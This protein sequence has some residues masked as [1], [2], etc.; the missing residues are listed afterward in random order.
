M[1]LNIVILNWNGFHYTKNCINSI[2]NSDFKDYKLIIV[3]NNSTDDSLH[4]LKKIF[5]KNKKIIFK[6]NK[7]NY[8]SFGFNFGLNHSNSE[9]V[10]MLNN[11]ALVNKNTL[12]TL[13]KTFQQNKRIGVVSPLVYDSKNNISKING[14]GIIDLKNGGGRPFNKSKGLIEYPDFTS[15]VC[16]MIKREVIN[17]TKGFDKRFFMYCDEV[18]WAIRINKLGYKFALNKLAKIVHIGGGSSSKVNYLRLFYETRNSIYLERIHADKKEYIIF[19]LKLSFLKIPKYLLNSKGNP[20][21]IL[22]YLKA[23]KCGLFDKI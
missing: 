20:K 6:K 4:K 8:G 11:D 3:D 10:M 23:I 19:L 7:K 17:K 15:G 12:S 16:W 18:E 9:Y 13:L 22:K 1:K 2:L 5:K 14:P 21:Y